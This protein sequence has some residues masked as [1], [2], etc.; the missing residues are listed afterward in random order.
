M[1][2]QIAPAIY[3]APLRIACVSTALAC[4][5]L[6][7]AWQCLVVNT[8]YQGNWTALFCTGSSFAA[9]PA[10]AG[11]RI[12][13]FPN[14]A[15]YDGQFYHY[16]AHDPLVR[17]GMQRYM[18]V[19]RRRYERILLP[20]M[21]FALALGHQPFIDAAFIAT[22]LLFLFLGAWWLGRLLETFGFRPQWAALFV[23]A[24]ATLIS[25]D[26]LTVDLAFAALCIGFALYVRL[27]QDVGVYGMVALACLSRE[28]GFVLAAAAC[29]P[30]LAQR[31]FAKAAAF[32]T[33]TL[34]A[35]AWY[36][37][38]AS[39]TPADPDAQAAHLMPLAG[40]VKV[41]I[42]PFSYSVADSSRTILQWLDRMALLGFVLAA[43]LTVW[44]VR[45]TRFGPVEAAMVLWSGLG[46]CLPKIVWAEPF[47]GPRLFTPL[48]IL[49]MVLGMPLLRWR[50]LVPMGMVLPR[51]ALQVLAPLLWY[52]GLLRR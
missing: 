23:L 26:R 7:W 12:Y 48:L 3:R 5:L 17:G 39:Q 34:P 31:R 6:G 20:A 32:A 29:L 51:V 25:L 46:L 8:R 15:G 14:S 21:A 33:A 18:D 11:E 35:A 40:I 50:A 13:V 45:R 19:P 28:T 43:L 47:A 4:A 52:F 1:P 2:P 44:I 36:L 49:V 30:L 10:L 24:P 16:A 27:K 37:Y 38:L 22:N 41:M 9:P 42:L